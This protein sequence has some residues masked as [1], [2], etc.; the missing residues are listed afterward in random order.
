MELHNAL[1]K[2]ANKM[3]RGVFFEFR[4]GEPAPTPSGQEEDEANKQLRVHTK[5]INEAGRRLII[6]MPTEGQ[7]LQLPKGGEAQKEKETKKKEKE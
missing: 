2:I 4:T 3:D 7:I 5:S 1:N 6:L